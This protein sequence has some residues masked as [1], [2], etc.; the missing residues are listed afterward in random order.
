MLTLRHISHLVFHE[1]WTLDRSRCSFS[2]HFY[3]QQ[4]FNY[5]LLVHVC[6]SSEH[7]QSL[8]CKL[9]TVGLY[10]KRW[11]LT[12]SQK[13]N[14]QTLIFV[15]F[16]CATHRWV[17]KPPVVTHS[18][19]LALDTFTHYCVHIIPHKTD[20]NICMFTCTTNHLTL[21]PSQLLERLSF[22]HVQYLSHLHSLYFLVYV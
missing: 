1:L 19:L 18:P 22:A 10:M 2:R 21:F 5:R 17:H 15:Q 4:D 11:A 13:K 9:K 3:S 16:K 20:C 12:T 7:S 14:S 8:L 6:S